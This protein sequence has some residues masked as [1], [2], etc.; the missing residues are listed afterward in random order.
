MDK[1]SKSHGRDRRGRSHRSLDEWRA[2]FRRHANS[3][4]AVSDFCDAESIPVS[5]FYKARRRV[6]GDLDGARPEAS[7]FL[8]LEPVVTS[9]RPGTAEDRAALLLPNGVRV[10]CI[11]DRLHELLALAKEIT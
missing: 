1:H 10:E 9:S 8:Q 7:G 2:I 3:D 6:A 5:S 11:G 4:L